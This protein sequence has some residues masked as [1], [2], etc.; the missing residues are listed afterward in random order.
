MPVDSNVCLINEH[1]Y[2]E[3]EWDELTGKKLNGNRLVGV[4]KDF[5]Y[6]DLYTEI[7]NLLLEKVLPDRCLFYEC[8]NKWKYFRKP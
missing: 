4:F 2:N 1:L 5:H 7:G 8:K 6:Q 3:L